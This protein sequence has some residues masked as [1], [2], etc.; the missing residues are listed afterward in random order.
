MN[1]EQIAQYA[2]QL[3]AIY[4]RMSA[5]QKKQYAPLVKE[6]IQAFKERLESSQQTTEEIPLENQPESEKIPPVQ[7]HVPEIARE[8]WT[9]ARGDPDVFALYVNTYPDP[10]VRAIGRIPGALD[11]IMN[12]INNTQ[13]ERPPG[14]AD[15]VPQA[16]LQSSNVYGARYDPLQKNL[17]VRFQGGSVYK[18]QGV[19]KQIFDMFISG[20]GTAR[21]KG[22]NRYGR[23]WVGKNPSIGAAFNNLIKLG[24]YPYQKIK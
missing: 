3:L 24:K 19:P 18:Y 16:P 11:K 4:E 6:A 1:K 17:T 7:P 10:S 12:E 22:N 8:L 14:Q 23:W 9:L 2:E 15:G 13:S 21:S 20:D 5:A